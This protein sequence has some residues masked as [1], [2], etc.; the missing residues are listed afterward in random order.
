MLPG[1]WRTAGYSW[2]IGDI[3][4]DMIQTKYEPILCLYLGK[5][6]NNLA[7]VI[8]LESLYTHIQIFMVSTGWIYLDHNAMPSS[9]WACTSLLIKRTLIKW[10][11]GT[12]CYSHLSCRTSY[13]LQIY[14]EKDLLWLADMPAYIC[15]MFSDYW[16]LRK[17]FFFSRQGR[18]KTIVRIFQNWNRCT[19]EWLTTT[20]TM[21]MRQTYLTPFFLGATYP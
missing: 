6:P 12:V 19:L 9:D 5:L 4:N 3:M 7:F 15:G 21:L 20:Q 2:N 8:F 16:I 11:M 13:C 17:S 14:T 1:I 10:N 18:R